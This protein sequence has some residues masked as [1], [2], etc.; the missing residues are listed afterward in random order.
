MSTLS[1]RVSYIKGLAEGMKLDTETNEGKII[2]KMLELLT[3]MAAEMDEMQN[4]LDELDEY[5]DSID[6]DLS[7]MEDL[8]YGEED[9]CGCGCCGDDD[10]D[11]CECGHHHC[12]C[13]CEDDDDDEDDSIVEYVCP[14]CG[15]EMTFEVDSF[16][17]DEDYLCPSCHNPLFPETPDEE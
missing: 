6:H 4:S 5:V 1:D 9:E 15:E 7:D 2:E 10:D 14:H 16:D 8:I 11:E 12:H 3:D 17:F 13:G